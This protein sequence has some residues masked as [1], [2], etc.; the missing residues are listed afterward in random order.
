MRGWRKE[1]I[2]VDG[3]E[4]PSYLRRRELYR[5]MKAQPRARMTKEDIQL[6]YKYDRWANHRVLRA[7]SSLSSQQFSR[8]LGGSFRS[9]RDT[10]LH[11]IASEWHEPA[12]GD[13]RRL[14]RGARHREKQRS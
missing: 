9:V 7:A 10:L 3:H 4:N 6:L 14:I 2:K 8:D 5:G 1:E 12:V 13:C 11:I